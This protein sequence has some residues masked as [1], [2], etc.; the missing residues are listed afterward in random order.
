LGETRIRKIY[1]TTNLSFKKF[2][3]NHLTSYSRKRMRL[4]PELLNLG[5]NTNES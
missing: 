5:G 1:W 4:S 3:F 2:V